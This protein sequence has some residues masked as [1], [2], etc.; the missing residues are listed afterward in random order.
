MSRLVF[1]A[2][3]V[4]ALALVACGG[5]DKPPLTPDAELNDGGLP[6]VSA[7]SATMPSAPTMPSSPTLPSAPKGPSAPN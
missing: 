7:P 5:G 4:T 2:S 6:S 1:F 3:F